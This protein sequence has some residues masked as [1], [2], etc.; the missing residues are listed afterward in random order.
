MAALTTA[1]KAVVQSAIDDLINT[2]YEKPL[3]GE[4]AHKLS[5]IHTALGYASQ[6]KILED[7]RDKPFTVLLSALI[8]AS[9]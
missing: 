5:T 6:I 7:L 2:G 9:S 3:A 1:E 4:V 8:L